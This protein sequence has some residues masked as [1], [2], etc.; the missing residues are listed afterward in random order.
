MGVTHVHRRTL[1]KNILPDFVVVVCW[2]STCTTST[3]V[4]S[5]DPE[6]PELVDPA[7]LVES[8]ELNNYIILV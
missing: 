3:L 7:S 2:S 4:E 6:L 5:E 1:M 8:L